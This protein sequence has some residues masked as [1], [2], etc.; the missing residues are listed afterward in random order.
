VDILT[1]T[2]GRNAAFE[3]IDRIAGQAAASKEPYA[4][5]KLDRVRRYIKQ[6][7][8]DECDAHFKENFD[9]LA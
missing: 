4:W 3:L 6:S 8:V 9:D 2:A 5:D 1:L 7:T